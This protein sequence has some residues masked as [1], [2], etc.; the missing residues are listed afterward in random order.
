MKV[1]D[2]LIGRANEQKKRIMGMQTI[3]SSELRLKFI[4]IRFTHQQK[5]NSKHLTPK[6]SGLSYKTSFLNVKSLNIII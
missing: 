1:L 5:Q 3:I 6:Y 2:V 4:L